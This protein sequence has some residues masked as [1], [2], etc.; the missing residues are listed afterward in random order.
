MFQSFQHINRAREIFG[1]II[2]YGFEDLVTSTSLKNL[3]PR[4]SRFTWLRDAR[5]V[6]EYTHWERIR[7]AVE[8]LGPTF[9]KGAQVL[10]NRPDLVPE[11]LAEELSKLQDRVQ[12]F[13][14]SEA[15][16]IIESETGLLIEELFSKFEEKPIGAASIGQVYQASLRT[17]EEV[18]VKV[19]RPKVRETVAADLAIIREIAK[20][21][22]TYFHRQGLLNPL[23]VVDAFERTMRRELDYQVEARS[24]QQFRKYYASKRDLHVPLVYEDLS[25]SNILVM[26]YVKG[27]KVNDIAQ[28]R[29]WGLNP[30]EIARKGIGLYLTQIFEHGYFHADPHPGNILVEP[31]GTIC[32]IDY[33]MVGRLM[34]RDRY[35]LS[36]LFISMGERDARMAARN[37]RNLALDDEVQDLFTLEYDI[38][39]LIED[40]ADIDVGDSNMTDFAERMQ[41]IISTHRLKVPGD[42]FL[43]FRALA[44]LEGI[45]KVIYPEFNTFEFVKPFGAKLLRQRF[46]PERIW[47]NLSFRVSD[48]DAFLNRFPVDLT[49]ILKKIRQGKL[50]LKL[51]QEDVSKLRESILTVGNRITMAF[52]VVGLLIASAIG[53]KA[54]LAP[55]ALT[56]SGIPYLSVIGFSLAAGLG[57]F[58][59]LGMWIK[60]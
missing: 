18:V 57:T 56:E 26:E 51:E 3:L 20:R 43:I 24:Q 42:T 36:G 39:E 2:K 41:K 45:G 46:A 12:P 1:V 49:E 17:G 52:M 6:M 13:D 23:D 22:E 31:N 32:L 54:D 10:S 9:V 58:L 14:F 30:K 34:A 48:L 38:N 16:T 55:G 59:I 25:T 28:L 19:M 8:E 40:F 50:H 4:K 33:G 5:P 15:K 35:S 27:C 44:I 21:G 29:E 60:K 53:M 37:L 47:Q 7:M 11:E